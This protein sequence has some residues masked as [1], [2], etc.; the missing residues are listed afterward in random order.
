MKKSKR[1]LDRQITALEDT[2]GGLPSLSDVWVADLSDGEGY[3][4]TADEWA[5]LLENQ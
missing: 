5:A 3:D 4:L 2:T 1:E